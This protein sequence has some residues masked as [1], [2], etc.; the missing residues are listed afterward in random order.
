MIDLLLWGCQDGVCTWQLAVEIC[1]INVN[2][3]WLQELC[4][5]ASA[6]LEHTQQDQARQ[7]ICRS[8]EVVRGLSTE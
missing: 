5:A 3:P 4:S 7:S 1:W 8:K 2:A 6:L